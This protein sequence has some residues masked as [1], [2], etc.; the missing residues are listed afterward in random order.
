[1]FKNKKNTIALSAFAVAS[2]LSTSAT[3]APILPGTLSSYSTVAQTL[4]LGTL[5]TQNMMQV[6]TT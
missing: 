6:R 1:M 2:L 5:T 4:V 3:A